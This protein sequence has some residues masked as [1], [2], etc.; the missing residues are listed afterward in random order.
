MRSRLFVALGVALVVM[1]QD[2]QAQ[3]EDRTAGGL[4]PGDYIRVS[5]GVTSPVNAQGSLRDWKQ[6]STVGLAW[7]NWQPGE[8]GVGRIGLSIGVSYSFLPLD[9]EQFIKNFTPLQGGTVT[10]ASASN[11]GVLEVATQ[12][13]F[14]IPAPLVMPT[15][16]AGIGFINWRPANV[17]YTGTAGSGTSKQRHRSGAELTIGGGLERHVADRFGI[18]AE[19]QYAYG[20]TS[21]GRSSTSPG[22]VCSTT[23][24]DVLKNTSVTTL[25][26]GLSVR[27]R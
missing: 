13:R 15:I 19:G 24:C 25:R 6:G 4:R 5:A 27:F 20:F 23:S 8:T 16:N 7:E 1:A 12:I 2:A 21:L 14:R 9:E 18:F 26:G 22:A 11:A 3:G 17:S 10:S